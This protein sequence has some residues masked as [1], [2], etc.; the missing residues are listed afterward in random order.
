MRT[1]RVIALGFALLLLASPLFSRQNSAGLKFLSS[2]NPASGVTYGEVTSC[3]DLG[4]IG[5]FSANSS[6]W[7]Y[8]FA[9]RAK[10]VQL[11]AIFV[12]RSVKDVQVHGRYLFVSFSNGMQWYDILDPR[13]PKLVLDFRPPEL[14]NAHTFFVSGNLLYVADYNSGGVR[15][16]NIT[17]KKNP[18]LV[19][20]ILDGAWGIHDMT[21]I[22]GRLYGAWINGLAGLSLVDV[23]NPAQPRELAKVRYAQAGT[24]NAWPTDDGKYI[25]TTDEVGA[26]R[27]TLKIWDARTPGRLTQVAEFGVGVSPASTIHNV[28]VRGR[29]AYMSYYCEGVRVVDIADPTKPQEV[30]FYDINGTTPC[31]GYNSNWG[32]DPFANV[33]FA[34]DLQRGLYALEFADHPTANISGQVVDARTN[35]PVPGAMV[36]FRD[37]Y[38][39]TRTNAA[40]KFD[41]PWFRDDTVRVVAEALGYRPDTSVVI[42]TAAGK[43]SPV[44]R[45]SSLT[46]AVAQPQELPKNFALL[47]SYPNPL[48]LSQSAP[49]QIAFRLPQRE[50]VQIEIF[51]V[52][53]QRVRALLNAPAEAGEHS[54]LWNGIDDRGQRVAAGI[55]LV[56]L[57]AANFVANSRITVIP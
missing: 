37:E 26:T 54:I 2:V 34:S 52:L 56:H 23:S 38:P 55:Y 30:A 44:I 36:Y 14:I 49:A 19:T 33:I 47:A 46:T 13:Q 50:N 11:A 15:I 45:L 28:Y 6:V 4:I 35:A 24:H 3:G 21:V 25:L 9:D 39:S 27:H 18:K 1:P 7:I 10:P 29:Y 16:Y 20:N 57:R 53:G 40:G 5:A 51:N 41:I 31:S 43:I 12:A 8:D 22:K 42:T 48:A 32:V 17:D